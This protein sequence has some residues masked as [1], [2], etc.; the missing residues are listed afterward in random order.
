[1]GWNLLNISHKVIE[2]PPLHIVLYQPEIPYNTGNIARLCAATML[3]LHLIFPVGISVNNRDLEGAWL[4]YWEEVDIRYHKSY[5]E[6][7]KIVPN[8]ISIIGFSVHAKRPY[9]EAKVTPGTYLMFG[10]ETRGLPQ[11]IKDTIPCYRIPIW[12]KVRSL[13]LS[14]SVGIVVYH[15][16][17][18]MGY[19]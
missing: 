15:Y 3:R 18:S 14:T 9:T 5:D 17:Y 8:N 19:F 12:G 4:D 2:D 7:L 16:L 13:N 10:P 6:F 1:L 11:E